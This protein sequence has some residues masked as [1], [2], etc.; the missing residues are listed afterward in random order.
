MFD[1]GW[2]ELLV[3]AIVAIIVVGPKDLP[4][5]LRT[6]GQTLGRL[7][8]MAGEFQGQFN[9]A[10]REA[11]L[12]DVRKEI[13]SVRKIDPMRQMRD[14]ITSV[15]RDVEKKPGGKTA[16]KPAGKA[17]KDEKAAPKGGAPGAESEKAP[18]AAKGG[19]RSAP[20]AS[21]KISP[22]RAAASS[23]EAGVPDGQSETAEPGEPPAGTGGAPT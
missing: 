15:K 11:E 17:A 18:T 14:Q 6:L 13:E 1:I 8:R 20:A 5:M 4:R 9:E 2:S 19:G 22:A 7:R 23:S 12:D 16:K 3:I 10:L 21:G